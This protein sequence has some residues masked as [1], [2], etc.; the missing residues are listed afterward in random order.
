MCGRGHLQRNLVE[1][2]CLEIFPYHLLRISSEI[3][4][5]LIFYIFTVDSCRI[6]ESLDDYNEEALVAHV[7]QFLDHLP[8]ILGKT[9]TINE[10]INF[11]FI[12]KKFFWSLIRILQK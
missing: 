12:I 1:G 8:I 2:R 10:L 3:T 9:Q 11:Y 6:L 5:R 7:K 4:L